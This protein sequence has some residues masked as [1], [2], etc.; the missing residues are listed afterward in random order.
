[1]KSIKK[2]LSH[3]KSIS[4]TILSVLGIALFLIVSPATAAKP[5]KVGFIGALS[6][7]YG[8]SNKAVLEIS[9][10]EINASG[11]ILGHPVQL[12][13]EDWKREVPLAVAAYKKLVM[14]EKCFL[15]FTEGT[16]RHHR[17][18]PG[19]LKALP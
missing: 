18:R 14:E 13:V 10:E 19:S 7:P 6:T 2:I 5:L 3:Q 16:E 12:I 15:V 11:G 17:L 9:V 8:A 1:M 4:G